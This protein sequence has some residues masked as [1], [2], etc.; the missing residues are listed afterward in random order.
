MSL[1]EAGAVGVDLVDARLDLGDQ[2]RPRREARAEREHLLPAVGPRSMLTSKN[3][4]EVAG[5]AWAPEPVGAGRAGGSRPRSSRRNRGQEAADREAASARGREKLRS[6]RESSLKSLVLTL[7]AGRIGENRARRDRPLLASIRSV[8]GRPGRARVRLA[9]PH[10]LSR[11]KDLEPPCPPR[12]IA[13]S[14]AR[15][16]AAGTSSTPTARR[17]AASPPASPTRSAAS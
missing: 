1:A 3:A 8:P 11:P 7:V 2:L 14:P 17:S 4:I 16:S 6:I 15:S 9:R 13:Q 10:D 12:P 5:A